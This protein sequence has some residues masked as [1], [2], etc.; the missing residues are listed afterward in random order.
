MKSEQNI[1]A[2]LQSEGF[3]NVEAYD[4][5]PGDGEEAHEHEFDVKFVMVSGDIEMTVAGV[6]RTLFP[7]DEIFVSRNTIHS[8]KA[9]EKGCRYVAGER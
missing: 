1:I 7:G 3:S 2:Q 5:L 9:G 6:K 8:S 4:E